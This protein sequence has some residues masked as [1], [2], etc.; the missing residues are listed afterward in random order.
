MRGTKAKAIRREVYG[1]RVTSRRGRRYGAMDGV[2]FAD[3]W[4]QRYQKAKR[5]EAPDATD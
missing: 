1:D 4:R 2:V 5:E 3:Q